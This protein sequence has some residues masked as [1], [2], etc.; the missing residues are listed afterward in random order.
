MKEIT[1]T[2]S[3]EEHQ[4]FDTIVKAGLNCRCEDI[5]TALFIHQN[6]LDITIRLLKSNQLQHGGLSFKLNINQILSIA[7]VYDFCL[8]G[9]A[10]YEY[11]CTVYSS[12][13]ALPIEGFTA[14]KLPTKVT[15]K[16]KKKPRKHYV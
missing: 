16:R 14:V 8:K 9:K 10:F 7:L 2:C 11:E 15:R 1:I 13:I 3:V 6:M 12:K 5:I 4:A